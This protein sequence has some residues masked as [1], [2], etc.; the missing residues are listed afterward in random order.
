[1]TGVRL[2][3]GSWQAHVQTPAGISNQTPV[4]TVAIPPPSTPTITQVT[5]SPTTLLADE[6]FSGSLIGTNFSLGTTRLQFCR[7]GTEQC[8][9]QSIRSV[10]IVSSTRVNV[11]EVRLAA[12]DWQA[13]LQVSGRLSNR[14]P[15]FRVLGKQQPVPTVG[16]YQWNP[17]TPIANQPFTGRITGTGFATGATRLHFCPPQTDACLSV[18]ATVLDP[19]QLEVGPVTLAAGQWDLQAETPGGA[20]PRTPPFSVQAPPPPLPTLLAFTPSVSTP[21]A[22]QPFQGVL[23]GT[24]F[25]TGSTE[26]L[27]CRHETNDCLLQPVAGLTATTATL[28]RIVLPEGRWQA[29]VRTR[30][31]LSNRLAP[32]SVAPSSAEQSPPAILSYTW[33]PDRPLANQ[34][35][36][37][38]ITG[39]GFV[40]GA[41]QL[42]FCIAGTD[43][44]SPHPLDR[45]MTNQESVLQVVNLVLS[46]ANWEFFLQTPRGN[47]Q[48]SPSFIVTDDPPSLPPVISAY[49]WR[50]VTPRANSVFEGVIIGNHFEMGATRVF[51]C[52][53]LTNNCTEV[54]AEK[55][56]VNT[57]N[58]LTLT[59]L[60]LPRGAWQVYLQTSISRS[61]RSRSF[62]VM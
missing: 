34:P 46:P 27:F 41:T 10:Q 30:E 44:C 11:V 29:Q 23:Q 2:A 6:P 58:S 33:N 19:T 18:E 53:N 55:V 51:F 32:F 5:W 4:F 48:R 57:P 62:L 25:M 49:L 50:P 20:S 61:S 60:T 47:S 28:D 8:L 26:V 31:G 43:T 36:T 7:T 12:G 35:F 45:T 9:T 22:S 16:T 37:G 39:T 17:T 42:Y 56:V 40:P 1:V 21:V 24:G 15:S 52:F 38:T 13:Q 3:S 14:S 54:A 59:D